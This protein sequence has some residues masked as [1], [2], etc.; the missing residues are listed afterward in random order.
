MTDSRRNSVLDEDP[1]DAEES[2]ISLMQVSSPWE[3]RKNFLFMYRSGNCMSPLASCF[4]SSRQSRRRPTHDVLLG[5]TS[6]K[7]VVLGMENSGLSLS[8][9]FLT[10]CAEGQPQLRCGYGFDGHYKALPNSA[11]G[12]SW[13]HPTYRISLMQTVLPRQS[14]GHKPSG[15]K[16]RGYGRLSSSWISR[17]I[18]PR[19][20]PNSPGCVLHGGA[21]AGEWPRGSTRRLEY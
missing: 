9:M 21:V 10:E 15:R 16:C 13:A 14:V 20:I 19:R 6:A 17:L 8:A 1:F 7:A 18:F 3:T 11:I 2:G 12:S 4:A 5:E